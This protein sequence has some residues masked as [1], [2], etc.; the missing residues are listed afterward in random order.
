MPPPF[1]VMV[2][3]DE[4]LVKWFSYLDS[5]SWAQGCL[6]QTCFYAF[7]RAASLGIP[8]GHA[9]SYVFTHLREGIL[10]FR[11]A[12]VAHQCQ[13]A[14]RFVKAG[15]TYGST[16]PARVL[17]RDPISLRNLFKYRDR[18]TELELWEN[19]P[20]RYETSKPP[21]AEE[22]IDLLFPGNPLLCVGLSNSDFRTDHREEF[23]G[24]LSNMQF[25]VSSPMTSIFGLTRDGRNSAHSL[26]NTGERKYLVVECDFDPNELAPYEIS[27]S[28]AGAGVLWWL[29][30]YAPL[31]LAVWS[32]SKSIHGWF[33]CRGAT[34]EHLARFMDVSY[35]LGADLATWRNRS[36]FVRMPDGLRSNGMRQ[37]ILWL[38][39][40]A[41]G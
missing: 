19:S 10:P 33:N 25:I 21:H 14:Y 5:L 23:R 16:L 2:G 31:A 18:W 27:A 40:R 35:S 39:P 34:D 41:C 29:K 20:I 4:S 12:K 32:G 24:T 11:A 8:H 36:Q 6:D 13:C 1:L 17:R 28:D 22:A 38:D 26:A 30:R 3:D 37:A 9:L 15:G 7:L